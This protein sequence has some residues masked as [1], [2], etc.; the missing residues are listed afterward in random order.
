MSISLV[1]KLFTTGA[2]SE[3]GSSGAFLHRLCIILETVSAAV[4][5]QR[6]IQMMQNQK[7][8]VF[9]LSDARQ[10]IL[11]TLRRSTSPR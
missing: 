5:R 2:G 10:Q 8:F 3:Q 9:G 7:L 11:P 6:P 1:A 4:A